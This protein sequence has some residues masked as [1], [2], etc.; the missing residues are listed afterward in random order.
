MERLENTNSARIA[1][2][3]ADFGITPDDLAHEVGISLA[4][5]HRAMAG[6]AGLTFNQLSKIAGFFGRGVLF[7][8][9]AGEPEAE[10][11]HTVAFRTIA[12]QK[13]E[14][15]AKIK[16]LIERVEHQ[17]TIYLALKDELGAED[18]PDFE[19]P[20]LPREAYDAATVARLW[21]A[22][23]ERNS[24]ETYRA[25][26]ESKGILVFLSNGYQG[27]WQI[28][29]E[30]PVIG[31]SL[32]DDQC[33]VIVVKK[34]RFESQQT[35]TLIHELGHL[36]M[37][38]MSSIDDEGDL[39]S[40]EGD[41]RLANAFAGQV[42]VPEGFLDQIDLAETPLTVDQYDGWL[43]RFRKQWGVSTEVILRRL[44]DSGRLRRDRYAAYRE[45]RAG[46]N[47]PI[48]DGGNRE[49][50]HREPKHIF[51][52]TFVR[53]VLDAM[54]SRYISLSKASSYL[55]GLKI[56]D[57]HKLERYYAGL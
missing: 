56:S 38:R 40:T 9:E 52:D 29:R 8:L 50:R 7:F 19:P 54:H 28:A 27:R 33:P 23:P 2:C 26:I 21:L 57:L 4:A 5:M 55:D 16:A 44:T 13:P 51:G 1:W 49:W 3:C 14:L 32:Y 41:E 37:Q 48:R 43:E 35:F 15:S 24:F 34:Q 36:L 6:E 22:L 53:A 39:H 25:A 20:E 10:R 30:S 47:E 45:W 42:L 31:F 12:N 11:M 46:V 17:R 18:F